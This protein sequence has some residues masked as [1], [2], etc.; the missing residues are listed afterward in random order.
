LIVV[1]AMFVATLPGPPA[2]AS[3][4]DT[5]ARDAAQTVSAFLFGPAPGQLLLGPQS[6]KHGRRAMFGV[7]LS[8][9]TAT[10]VA[11][12]LATIIAQFI[13]FRVAEALGA[14]AASVIVNALVCDIFDERTSASVVSFVL[15][16]MLMVPL[17]APIIGGHEIELAGWRLVFWSCW[18][19][20]A[21]SASPQGREPRSFLPLRA[22]KKGLA[23]QVS[24][25]GPKT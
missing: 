10:S 23:R 24:R 19:A 7:S 21:R 12:T 17:F 6:H 3:D 22:S 11:C 8:V 2:I 1:L 25:F 20:M 13:A 18:P 9:F 5:D 15:M 14:G 16:V 4:L